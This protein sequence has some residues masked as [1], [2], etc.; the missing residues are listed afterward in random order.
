MPNYERYEKTTTQVVFKVKGSYD[1]HS[2]SSNHAELLRAIHAARV[3]LNPDN[4]GN[5]A[6]DVIKVTPADE[7]ILVW[8][9]K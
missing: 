7:S 4:P 2:Y 8:Y 9:E 1:G 5:V 6:D 3:E